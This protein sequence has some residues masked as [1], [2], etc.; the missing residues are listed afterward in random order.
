M[1][2]HFIHPLKQAIRNDM[3][4]NFSIFM[5]LSS[6]L[7]ESKQELVYILARILSYTSQQV[8]K[9]Q[10]HHFVSVE[11][12]VEEHRLMLMDQIVGNALVQ[13]ISPVFFSSMNEQPLM[14]IINGLFHQ[15]LCL[16]QGVYEELKMFK[17][18]STNIE[19]EE[20]E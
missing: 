15:V 20:E 9:K 11:G 7:E 13:D 10:S 19:I 8:E 6:V 4:K 5:R 2:E 17:Q 12:L 16:K 3:L 18:E 1:I 14:H